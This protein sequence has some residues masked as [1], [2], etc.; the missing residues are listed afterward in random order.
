M[1]TPNTLPPPA[2]VPAAHALTTA[3]RPGSHPHPA[4]Q[5]PAPGILPAIQSLL[6]LIVVAS[7]ILT[8]TVQPFRIPSESMEP[9]LLVG[10]F[11]L[12]NK[13]SLGF[14]NPGGILPPASI[15]RGEI[16]VFHYPVAPTTHLIK[17]VVG[18]PGD[19]LRMRNNRV[20]INGQ[21]LSES[22]AVYRPSPH[23]LFR[24]NFP[25][26]QSADPSIDSDWWIAMHRLINDGDLIIP[27]GDYFVLGD[28]RN[29]S[30]D[31]RYWG[32]V[33]RANI[34]GTPLLIYFSLNQEAPDNDDVPVFTAPRPAPPRPTLLDS[35]L[36]VARWDRTLRLVH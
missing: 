14:N 26:L 11:L 29:D 21:P 6:Y 20:Y 9:T 33:P 23:D 25:R 1:T 31:S 22:Y 17:R 35:L 2:E 13:L 19:R 24:D 4:P 5:D 27:P 7:F 8:F 30:E 34:V 10:D 28:N 32:F 3:F 12:V 18:I 16:I 15:H 36:N